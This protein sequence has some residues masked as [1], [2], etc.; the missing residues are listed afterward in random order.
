M[1]LF[2]GLCD[3]TKGG[4]SRSSAPWQQVKPWTQV[5]TVGAAPR[6]M[7]ILVVLG[8]LAPKPYLDNRRFQ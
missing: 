2:R 3:D 4:T 1:L 8:D 5:G 6:V 7:V